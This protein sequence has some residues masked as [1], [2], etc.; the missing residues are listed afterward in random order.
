MPKL[1]R[2]FHIINESVYKRKGVFLW[3]Y[4]D[5]HKFF[6][7]LRSCEIRFTRMDEFEDPL[8]GV[9]LRAIITYAG[10][11]DLDLIKDEK[12]S[13]LILDRSKFSKL[14]VDMQKRIR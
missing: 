8:E 4:F 6:S 14:S 12:L 2:E 3:R 7:F 1:K 13:D 11:R 10:Q 5:L 9:P